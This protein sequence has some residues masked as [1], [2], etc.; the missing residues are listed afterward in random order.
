MR[1]NMAGV[2]YPQRAPDFLRS[3]H[4]VAEGC[5]ATSLSLA[6]MDSFD[7]LFSAILSALQ[8]WIRS[9]SLLHL[10]WAFKLKFKLGTCL[11]NVVPAGFRALRQW[12]MLQP[13]TGSAC[14]RTTPSCA[15]IVMCMRCTRQRSVNTRVATFIKSCTSS[16]SLAVIATTQSAATV[17]I[18]QT[19]RGLQTGRQ[20]ARLET[21]L[22]Q[23]GP[24]SFHK[25]HL[26]CCIRV[27]AFTSALL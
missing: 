16:R 17:V 22:M 1:S 6:G 8:R 12:Q 24:V 21:G 4:F 14:S 11:T 13:V 9:V 7:A 27:R 2:L 25:V 15:A 5:A 23:L 19:C 10:R 20:P 18:R 3:Q 26:I